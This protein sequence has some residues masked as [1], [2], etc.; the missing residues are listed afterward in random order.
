MSRQQTSDAEQLRQQLRAA[1]ERLNDG[2]ERSKNTALPKFLEL[3][4]TLFSEPLRV[5]SNQPFTTKGSI[6]SPLGKKHSTYLCP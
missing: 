4:H 2:R 1:E 3:C 5:Q 6:T